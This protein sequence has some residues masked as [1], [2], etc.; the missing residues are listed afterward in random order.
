[1]LVIV[2]PEMGW[3]LS[4]DA[5]LIHDGSLLLERHSD[6]VFVAISVES[7][8]SKRYTSEDITSR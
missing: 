1:V 5:H 8:G 4:G 3:E 7:Y 2:S 6:W